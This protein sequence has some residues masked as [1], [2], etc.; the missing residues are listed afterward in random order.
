MKKDPLSKAMAVMEEA[1]EAVAA[2]DAS[3]VAWKEAEA[4]WKALKSQPPE[5]S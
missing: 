5:G 2:R 4:A 3:W 1:L